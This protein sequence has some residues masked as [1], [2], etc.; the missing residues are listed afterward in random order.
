MRLPARPGKLTIRP[1]DIVT[2]PAG[3]VS[4]RIHPSRGP[5]PQP[6][7]RLR[8][9]GPTASRFDPHPPP[10]RVH[11]G[12]AVSYTAPDPHTPFAEVY[13]R[14]RTI[15]VT[16]DSPYL[17]AWQIAR[18]VRLLDLTG[19]WPVANGASHALNTGRHDHCRAWAHAIHDHPARVD[20]LWHT[21]AITGS[22][23]ATLFTPAANS[24]PPTPV[25]SR[26]LADPALRPLILAVA[27]RFNYR[28]AG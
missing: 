12:Y 10:P 8:F 28:T 23:A 20:G 15:N 9:Y 13:Q 25:F 3:T 27:H 16:A 5:H 22:P 2:L 1:G 7:N 21:S 18:P 11:T 14:A 6:W 19:D 4:W 26:A 24:F 17:T